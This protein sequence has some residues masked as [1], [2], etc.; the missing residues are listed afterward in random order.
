M[1][2]NIHKLIL[3]FRDLYLGLLYSTEHQRIFGYVTN[4]K[5]KFVIIVNVMQQMPT[6]GKHKERDILSE[7]KLL[8]FQFFCRLDN[9]N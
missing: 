2:R 4:T 5:I 9:Q 8:S 1:Q 3:F 7:E 6:L